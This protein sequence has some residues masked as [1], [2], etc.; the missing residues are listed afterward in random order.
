MPRD[1]FELPKTRDGIRRAVDDEIQAHLDDRVTELLRAGHT[2]DDA[3]AQAMR[4]FGDLDAARSDLRRIDE[5][6]A[7]HASI[8]DLVRDLGTDARRALRGLARRPGFTLVAVGTLALGIGAN[9]VMFGLIDRLLLSGPP[10]VT[11]P[12]RVTR[13]MF[14]QEN[15]PG[16]ITWVRAPQPFYRVLAARQDLFEGVAGYSD[17]PLTLAIGQRA[18]E[19]AVAAVTPNYFS[20]LGLRTTIGRPL[21]SADDGSDD[22]AVVLSHA[23]WMRELGGASNAI[24]QQVRLGG[25]LFTVVGVAPRGF[26]GDGVTPFDAWIRLGNSTP[27]L[28][29]R[30]NTADVFTFARLRADVPTA[31]VSEETTRLFRDWLASAQ[32]PDST[33]RILLPPMLAGRTSDTGELTPQARVAVWL[34][35]VSILV[36]IIAVANVVNLLLLRAIERQRET[37][38]CL[39]LGISRARLVR[40]LSLES[41]L[42]AVAGGALAVALARWLGPMLWTV[43]V[44]KTVD[45]GPIAGRLTALAAGVAAIAAVIMTVVPAMVQRA[46]TGG[47]ALRSA[48]RGAT[49]QSSRLGS[50]LVVVQVTLTVV[51]L[52]GAGLFVRSV[53]RLAAIDIGI[54]A[55]QIV[56]ARVSPVASSTPADRI[57][58]FARVE[59]ALRRLPGVRSVAISM[60]APFRP[61]LAAPFRLPGHD[62]LPGVGP[63]ALGAP[64]FFAV[65]PEFLETMGIRLLRGRNFTAADRA[66][67]A[68]VMLIDST[69]GAAFWPG[70]E[71][72]GKCVQIGAD[73]IPCT[74][75]VGVV[76][77]TRRALTAPNHSLRYYLP[78]EQ[79]VF[80]PA[81]R[82][83]FVRTSRATMPM[84]DAVRA[85]VSTA[86]PTAPFVESFLA[87]RLLDPYTQQWRLGTT[88]FVS[89]GVLA[90]LI[91]TIGLFG[92]VS[93]GVARRE[94]ELGIRRALGESR[95]SV[96][97]R[98]VLEAT[99]RSV[100]GLAIGAG[101]SYVLGRQMKDVL[102]NP[103]AS[104]ALVFLAATAIV[105]AATIVASAGPASRAVRVDPMH[106]LRTE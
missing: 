62:R 7:R 58:M 52:V 80:R 102:Y 17:R 56:G 85:A 78:I 97:R 34:Q 48:S 3:V 64:T 57:A 33:A 44:P 65:S 39:A 53:Q 87:E 46:A 23:V 30:W 18:S 99:A 2:R 94:R 84:T 35:A 103:S 75:I 25:E 38:V 32:R 26:T 15:P 100:I 24:G 90:T 63:N 55:E 81:D 60:S 37:A 16:R 96:V 27:T 40:H 89:F 50:A 95:A 61:S 36:L 106:A 1:D 20:L 21:T 67:T 73:S 9:A 41:L 72:I 71:A 104:D 14:N 66:G 6:A 4:E 105:L 54:D 12:D 70:S 51:L 11:D 68:R 47:D 22:R 28:G 91:A 98:V 101:L 31:R 83:F 29:A 42:L 86:A 69:M 76:E 93:F 45:A 82:Y 43:V 79:S 92:I 74:T 19:L 8:V 13:V 77:D 5:R 49:R 10:H 59:D 88:A